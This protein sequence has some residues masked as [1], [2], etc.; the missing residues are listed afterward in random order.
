MGVDGYL[1]E[2][3]WCLYVF[4]GAP[5]FFALSALAWYHPVKW[6]QQNSRAEYAMQDDPAHATR[7]RRIRGLNKGGAVA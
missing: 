4:E 1:F 7:P 6:M 2:H 3:E 5:M